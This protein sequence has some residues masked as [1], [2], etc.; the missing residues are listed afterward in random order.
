MAWKAGTLLASEPARPVDVKEG[1]DPGK[2][3]QQTVADGGGNVREGVKEV[4]Q[5]VED[6]RQRPCERG[7]VG[8]CG[9]NDGQQEDRRYDGED[10][11]KPR[12]A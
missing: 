5:A 8:D 10:A 4:A 12:P 1:E 6:R 11:R 9:K 2:S 3:T 7:S